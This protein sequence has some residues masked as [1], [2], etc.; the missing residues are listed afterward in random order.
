MMNQFETLKK[1]MAELTQ[2]YYKVLKRNAELYLKLCNLE[3]DNSDLRRT[4]T[5]QSDNSEGVERK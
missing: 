3:E 4:T 2:C 5:S 1:D